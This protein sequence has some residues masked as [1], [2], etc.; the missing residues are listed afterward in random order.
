MTLAAPGKR[1][2]ILCSGHIELY[3]YILLIHATVVYLCAL[4][5]KFAT[6]RHDAAR[7]FSAAG[8]VVS[9]HKR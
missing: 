1:R 9:A 2:R 4:H 3:L 6:H 7:R 5:V 8:A